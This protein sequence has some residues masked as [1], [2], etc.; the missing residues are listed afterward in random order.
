LLVEAV[1]AKLLLQ[2]LVTLGATT[3]E[4]RTGMAQERLLPLGYLRGVN[5][6]ALRDLVQGLLLA[7]RF[8]RYFAFKLGG[9]ST[10]FLHRCFYLIDG[11]QPVQVYPTGS[12]YLDRPFERLDI[13]LDFYRLHLENL[14]LGWR[15]GRGRKECV[16][17]PSRVKVESDY[18]MALDLIANLPRTES[19][20]TLANKIMETLIMMFAANKVR[21]LSVSDAVV[22]HC[23]SIP[24]DLEALNLSDDL[25]LSPDPISSVKSEAGFC[26]RI[27]TESNVLAYIEIDDL[28]LP[29]NIGQYENLALAMAE[30][31]A[32]AIEHTRFFHRMTEMNSE[33]NELNLTKDKL[34]SILA[35]DLR[36]PFSS[37]LGSAEILSDD[38]ENLGAKEVR[39]LLGFIRKSAEETLV[40]LENLLA[41]AK[42]QTGRLSFSPKP[43][44]LTKV[45]KRVLETGKL[46]AH[47]KNIALSVGVSDQ[48]KVYSDENMLETILRNLISNAVK[49]THSGG[50]IHVSARTVET[51]AEISVSDS[52]IGMSPAKIKNLFS[53]GKNQSTRGTEDEAGSG[54]GLIFCEELV[55]RQNGKIWAESE[56][57][58]GSRIKF[59]T[60]LMMSRDQPEPLID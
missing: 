30:V 22:K 3:F 10:A 48:L 6:V 56:L 54:L 33:L 57:G 28:S 51:H 52:G 44:T 35:H 50:S 19:E 4:N 16:T 32:L 1:F 17:V 38:F 2:T 11:K 23:W 8:E 21:Y 40:L 45:L 7:Q 58:K 12:A 5:L 43:L 18:A 27:G 39:Q 34:L 14:V 25:F 9:E 31:F 41:W 53:L 46:G 26:L 47:S 55:V 36:S 59:T 13:G 60:P 24:T 29:E 20:E 15:L 37:I 49:F 42:T